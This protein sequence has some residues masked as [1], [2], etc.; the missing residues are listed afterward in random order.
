[1][2]AVVGVTQIALAASFA[3]LVFSGR[4]A[5]RLPAGIGL[6]LFAATITTVVIALGSSFP[7]TVGRV[8]D[9]TTTI[10]ALMAAAIAARLA[11]SPGQAFLTVVAALAVSTIITGIF[12]LLIGSFR[13]GNLIRFIPYPVMAGFLAGTGW[14]LVRGGMVVLTGAPL[15]F[16]ALSG[17]AHAQRLFR[18]LPAVMG[19]IVALVAVRRWARPLIVPA[20]V[21]GGGLL[22]YA[23]F[24]VNGQ[25]VAAA[26]WGGWLLGP[27]PSGR[28]WHPWVTSA[29]S[30]T[31]WRALLSQAA[32]LPSLLAVAVIHLL[33]SCSSIELGV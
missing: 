30:K 11:S 20:A 12:F 2:G 7:G 18:W 1:M 27:F 26:R 25:S 6:S 3:A 23:A 4:L 31:N 21:I 28:L 8:Q 19:A 32:L 10:A 33:M 24:L 17:M 29:L 16:S 22:F 5:S 9:T 15:S 14:L 13:L